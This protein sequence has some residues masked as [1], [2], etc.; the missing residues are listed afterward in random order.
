[1]K[2]PNNILC[3]VVKN[4]YKVSHEDITVFQWIIAIIIDLPSEDIHNIILL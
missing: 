1:M 2:I 3:E 4:K